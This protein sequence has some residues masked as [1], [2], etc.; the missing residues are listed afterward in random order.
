MAGGQPGFLGQRKGWRHDPGR[1][2]LRRPS[3][4]EDA[5]AALAAGRRG[6]QGAGRRAEPASRCCGCAWPRR[7]SLVDLGGVA[8]LRGVRDDGDAIV[9]GAM[10]T[11]AEV[12][13]RPAGRA[14]TRRWSPQAT[15]TV[16][17][18]QVRHRGTFGGSLAH[19]D[20]AGDLPA[21]AVAST[22]SSRS[23]APAGGG[24]VAAADFF[25]DFLTT[26]LGPDEVLVEVRLPKRA[27]WGTHYEKF[28][29]TAQAWAMVGV[30]A[31][32]RREN[33]TIAEARVALTNMGS[34]PVRAAGVEA[35]LGRCDA[36]EPPSPRRRRTRPRARLRR[37][38]C[39]PRP[40]TA[41]TWSAC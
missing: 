8:E 30:A 33:G 20:P 14:S 10:T 37:P 23:P 6:R 40:T 18:R 25:I 3:S 2:R 19:A 16:G 17:D 28:H 9:I 7:R 22:R 26:A 4:V 21:V 24:S 34:T 39:R 41:A 35:A 38:T 31:A 36:T 1:V 5:V 29:R 32:V 11:H 15:A 12:L 27:G 13:A